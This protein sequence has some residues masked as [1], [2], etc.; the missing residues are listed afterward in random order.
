MRSNERNAGRPA[1]TAVLAAVGV[2][3]LIAAAVA[4]GEPQGPRI[5]VAEPRYDFGEVAAGVMLEHVFEIKNTGDEV[6]V[7]RKIEPS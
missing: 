1:R 2:L 3:L 4:A 5:S 7:I 6:L